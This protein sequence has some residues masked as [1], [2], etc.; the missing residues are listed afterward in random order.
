MTQHEKGSPGAPG[1]VADTLLYSILDAMPVPVFFKDD[2]GRYLGFNKAFERFVGRTREEMVGKPLEELWDAELAKVYKDADEALLAEGGAQIYEAQVKYADG[3]LHD[4]EY[5]KAVFHAQSEE[6]T[7]IVGVM[8]DI[9]YRNQAEEKLRQ[10]ALHDELTG[11]ANRAY[12]MPSLEQSLRR[13][14][15]LGDELA[16]IVLDLDGFKSINDAL[17]H[18]VGDD[19]LR[20]VA[21]RLRD[22]VRDSDTVARLGGD[23]FVIVIDD[24][25]SRASVVR[26]VSTIIN[27]LA[28]PIDIGAE[29]LQTGTSVGVAIG[30]IIDEDAST[31][32][33]RADAAIYVAKR[34]PASNY[35]I[36]GDAGLS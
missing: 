8:L 16:L 6:I 4:V 30:P 28:E 27:R 29:Q 36:D 11:L 9:T 35:H 7:G 32:L 17:G 15:R 20:E 10:M 21:R 2:Q 23:E 14:N 3:S 12:L 13:A 19:V 31:L 5:H 33:A 34:N 26:V 18:A 22:S 25:R 1:V 24:L